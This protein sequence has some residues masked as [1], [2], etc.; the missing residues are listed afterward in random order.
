[1]HHLCAVR[2]NENRMN[3]FYYYGKLRSL[4]HC[5]YFCNSF[6]VYAYMHYG[7][8]STDAKLVNTNGNWIKTTT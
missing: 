5:A 7:K 1:M 4:K 3:N 6:V 2:Q 8:T